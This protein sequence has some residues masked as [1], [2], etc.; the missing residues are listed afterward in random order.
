MHT[1]ART[2]AHS[3][4]HTRTN[5]QA[6]VNLRAVMYLGTGFYPDNQ[7]MHHIYRTGDMIPQFTCNG[8]HG[9]ECAC[10]ACVARLWL[11]DM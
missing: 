3:H 10:R 11:D 9:C 6:V 4:I 2:H 1:H 7:S 5:K 8:L